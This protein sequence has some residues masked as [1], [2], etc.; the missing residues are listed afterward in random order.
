ME[1]NKNFQLKLI[2]NQ[3]LRLFLITNKEIAIKKNK[4]I[5]FKEEKE[6][7][8]QNKLK[9]M[10]FRPAVKGDDG[11]IEKKI[12]PF[13]SVHVILKKI[14]DKKKYKN[15]SSLIPQK[16]LIY[17]VIRLNKKLEKFV[18]SINKYNLNLNSFKGSKLDFVLFLRNNLY[19]NLKIRFS[20]I[21]YKIDLIKATYN[22]I[23]NFNK[24]NNINIKLSRL[25]MIDKIFAD[26]SVTPP[27]TP[28]SEGEHA[29]NSESSHPTAATLPTAAA[30][31][32]SP[33]QPQ[34]EGEI[35]SP[36][37]RKIALLFSYF[38]NQHSNKLHLTK[39]AA[40]LSLATKKSNSKKFLLNK[41]FLDDIVTI[42]DNHSKLMINKS[43]IPNISKYKTNVGAKVNNHLFIYSNKKRLLNPYFLY[44]LNHSDCNK[45]DIGGVA[46][47]QKFIKSKE[48]EIKY[49]L[50]KLNSLIKKIKYIINIIKLNKKFL[51]KIDK[52]KSGSKV[53]VSNI[54][55]PA[56]INNEI[57]NLRLL[58]SRGLT[59]QE[60]EQEQEQKQGKA[61][62]K[63][64]LYL[65]ISN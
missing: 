47:L 62:N 7:I 46:V 30:S 29:A 18:K 59:Q 36:V 54:K 61:T 52:I 14:S 21:L 16:K 32:A 8:L 24:N 40:Y 35:A 20:N 6:I 17:K 49:L 2:H 45:Q 11:Q 65:Q 48:S 38:N 13:F 41:T 3:H 25:Q 12:L 50:F 43:I 53:K 9:A 23:I 4:L 27:A 64:N 31:A 34:Q 37:Q 51:K 10:S 28:S 1:L 39:K 5:E 42:L 57:K 15:F 63:K 19:F 56:T 55:D 26:F 60:Q 33:S 22:N 44:L 58:R